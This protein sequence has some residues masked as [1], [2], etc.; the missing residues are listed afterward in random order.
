MLVFGIDEDIVRARGGTMRNLTI[1]GALHNR[2]QGDIEKGIFLKFCHSIGVCFLFTIV[3]LVGTG[4]INLEGC[5]YG[6]LMRTTQ[7][8]RVSIIF[9][10]YATELLSLQ[11]LGKKPWA[12]EVRCKTR[13]RRRE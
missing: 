8:K 9:N 6:R 3:T 13:V 2:K 11:G 10:L 7:D 4:Q 1:F 5:C 12:R